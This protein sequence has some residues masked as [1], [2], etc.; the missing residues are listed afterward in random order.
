MRMYDTRKFDRVAQVQHSLNEF[1]LLAADG[2]VQ[3]T[4]R[5]T[6][7]ARYIY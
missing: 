7:S 2:S 1:E 6:V 4:H 3:T 5:S